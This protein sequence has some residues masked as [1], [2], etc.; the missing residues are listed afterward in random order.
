[1]KITLH[2]TVEEVNLILLGLAELPA[3]TSMA[4]IQKVHGE[5]T[6]QVTK[7]QNN[8]TFKQNGDSQ[9]SQEAVHLADGQ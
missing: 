1:M 7:T 4:L 5:S 9:T 6:E 3:K 2:L 8:Q